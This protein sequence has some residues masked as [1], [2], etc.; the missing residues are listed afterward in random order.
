MS[1]PDSSQ[2]DQP[3]SPS[4]QYGTVW[5]PVQ[6]WLED[7]DDIEDMD[8]VPESDGRD[9]EDEMNEDEDAEADEELSGNPTSSEVQSR[10]L[11]LQPP[12]RPGAESWR[13]PD[14]I[15]HGRIRR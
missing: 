5:H 3:R 4:R 8:Y 2:D 7:E 6:E 13:F 9:D 15:R 11:K 10:I 1:P 14:P 12:N